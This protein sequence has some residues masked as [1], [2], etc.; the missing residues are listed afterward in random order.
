M[1]A[2]VAAESE[3]KKGGSLRLRIKPDKIRLFDPESERAIS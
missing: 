2:R 1:V 3:A